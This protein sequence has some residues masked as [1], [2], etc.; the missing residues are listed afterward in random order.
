MKH[1]KIVLLAKTKLTSIEVSHI[2]H[3]HFVLVNNML[4]DYDV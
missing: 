3:D 2:S 4:R 1:D